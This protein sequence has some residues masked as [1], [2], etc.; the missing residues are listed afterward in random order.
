M[1]EE[2][3]FMEFPL[4]EKKNECILYIYGYKYI[5]TGKVFFTM[6]W[7]FGWRL[8][9]KEVSGGRIPE[10]V[11]IWICPF[12]SAL[13]LGLSFFFCEDFPFDPA[14][15]AVLLCGVPI[16]KE[17]AEGL[18]KRFDIKAD[19]LVA[20]ALLAALWIGEVFAAGEVALIMI[21]G[22]RLE[23]RTVA[24]ARSGIEKLLKMMPRTARKLT[25]EGGER[26]IPAS[27]LLPGDLVRI[28]AGEAIPA[29]GRVRRGY[30]SVDQSVMTGESLPVDKVPGDFVSSGTVNQF[31]V[32][33]VEVVNAGE[34]SL[35]GR[36]IRLAESAEASKSK[37][38]RRTDRWAGW[39]VLCAMLAAIGTWLVT[40]E[41]I[42]SVSVLVVFCPCA[43]V[44]ATPTAMMAGIG[45]ASSF[46]VL[47][48][49]G[50]ALEALAGVSTA[51]FDKT[52]TLTEGNLSVT[53]LRSFLPDELSSEELL[54]SAALL[55]S[56]SEHP[57]GKAI[58]ESFLLRR[59][60]VLSKEEVSSFRMFPG[61]GVAGEVEGRIFLAGNRTLLQEQGVR[62][63]PEAEKEAAELEEKGC[64]VIL[65]ARDGKTAGLIGLAD[66]IRASAE[67]TV[68]ELRRA[69]VDSILISGDHASPVRT[70][71]REAGIARFHA[72]CL[73]ENKVERILE[74]EK[75]GERVCMIGDGVNDAA[76][77]KTASVG[78]S[79][80]GI[81]SDIAIDSSDIVFVHDDISSLPRLLALS[82]RTLKTIYCNIAFSMILNF[83][84]VLLAMS[85][86]LGPFWG[87]LVHNAGSVAVIFNS[88][89]LLKWKPS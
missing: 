37:I 52:G 85:G 83:A 65:I 59:Q 55:E 87:A 32:L 22:E 36:M 57:A 19:L 79:M 15:V 89:L 31:G 27:E 40:G 67:K 4:E 80:G 2:N 20:T 28:L 77:L 50:G 17:A 68:A 58:G 75:N 21:L 66:R 78:I 72:E 44:L 42:R 84:A 53:D 62:I 69:G 56:C 10:R 81:G 9:K 38:V 33:D 11:R 12:V 88:I 24:K 8:W 3:F 46:G 23:E 16:L 26:V 6:E 82:R 60:K 47:I 76:A 7:K 25:V 5:E 35:L 34:K 73:P 30:S 51:A 49:N 39:I 86:F 63:P 48:R 41:V 64:S 74:M 18:V 1:K 43:L 61:R 54:R 71:A 29:D 14:W 45:N 70:I 13:S